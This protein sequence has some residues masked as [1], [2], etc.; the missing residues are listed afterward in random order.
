MQVYCKPREEDGQYDLSCLL[1]KKE[2]PWSIDKSIF[3]NFQ[4]DNDAL[5]D[6]CFLFDFDSSK[7]LRLV[8]EEVDDVRETLCEFYPFL[9]NCYKYYAASNLGTVNV[10]IL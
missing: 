8:K 4:P 10:K 9:F 7:I 1:N 2:P 5:I 3:I 6:E